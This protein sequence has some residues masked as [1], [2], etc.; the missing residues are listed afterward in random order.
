MAR[1]FMGRGATARG[2]QIAASIFQ[3]ATGDGERLKCDVRDIA[4]LKM[5]Q[6]TKSRLPG[7]DAVLLKLQDMPVLAIKCGATSERGS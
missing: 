1:C 7:S 3:P 4:A 6:L 5:G 2:C